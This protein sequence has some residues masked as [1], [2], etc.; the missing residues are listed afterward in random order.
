MCK[1]PVGRG[2]RPEASKVDSNCSTMWCGWE[3][4]LGRGNPEG[5]M[6]R[7]CVELKRVMSMKLE[8]E[9]ETARLLTG[10]CSLATSDN[11]L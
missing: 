5:R 7:V 2:I 6:S 1:R 4:K 3:E 11:G 10:E 9:L 8:I